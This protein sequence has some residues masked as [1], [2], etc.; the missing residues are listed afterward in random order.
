[1]FAVPYDSV[2][3]W[4]WRLEKSTCKLTKMSTAEKKEN[5]ISGAE[6][7]LSTASLN[8][9]QDFHL[10]DSEEEA[11]QEQSQKIDLSKDK[12]CDPVVKKNVEEPNSNTVEQPTVEK[13]TVAEKSDDTCKEDCHEK[14][15]EED[16]IQGTPPE[17]YVSTKK[18]GLC[19]LETIGLKRKAEFSEPVSKLLRMSSR[20][21]A[22][23]LEKKR[24]EE[25]ESC[26]SYKIEDTQQ[27]FSKN[28]SDTSIII[29][30]SQDPEEEETAHDIVQNSTEKDN[31]DQ[32][33]R[34][35]ESHSDNLQE[36]EKENFEK[37]NY[38]VIPP[39]IAD[40]VEQTSDNMSIQVEE[41]LEKTKTTLIA[42]EKT[43][44]DLINDEENKI[45][46]PDNL[47]KSDLKDHDNMVENHIVVEEKDDTDVKSKNDNVALTQNKLEDETL[48]SS[49]LCKSRMSVEVIYDRAAIIRE[50]KSKQKELVQIDEDGEKI[51]LDSSQDDYTSTTNN[52]NT[53]DNTNT[54]TIY[55]SCYESKNSSDYSY[56][57]VGSGT[58]SST[59]KKSDGNL[60]NGSNESKKCDTDGTA[61]VGSDI[62]S[63]SSPVV[64]DRG[65]SNVPSFVHSMNKQSKVNVSVSK[66]SDN[67]DLLSV[68][69]NEPDISIMHDDTKNKSDLVHSNS[70]IKSIQV[71]KEI[72]VYL[73][74]KCLLQID[75]GTK[76]FLGKELMSVHCEPIIE[77]AV[78]RQRNDD[79]LACL[80]DISGNDNKDTSP[81]SVNSN[82][83]PYVLNPSRLSFVST[84]SSSSSASSAASLASKLASRDNTHFSLPRVP[85]KHVKKHYNDVP[86]MGEKQTIDESYEHLT[87][88]WKNNDLLTTSVLS[89]VNAELNAVDTYNVSNE[90]LDDQL[91]KI[92]SSTPEAYREELEGITPKSTRRNKALKRPRS[93]SSK[94]ST[95]SNGLS[96]LSTNILNS[97]EK[98]NTPNNRKK[99]KIEN[100]DTTIVMSNVNTPSK[101]P[102]PSVIVDE[103]IGKEVFAKW[104]DNNYYPGTV[105]DKVKTKYKVSFYDGKTKVLIEDFVIPIPKMLNEG[106][107]V[108]ATKNDDYGSCGII[109]DVQTINNEVYYVVETDEGEKIKVQVRNIFL[110]SDQAQVLK[111]ET[112]SDRKSLP[113]TP[114]HLGQITLDNMIDGKRRSKRIATPVFNTPK[115]KLDVHSSATKK[116]NVAEPSVSGV[117]MKPKKERSM[118]SETDGISSDASSKV[119]EED[120][121]NGVQPEIIG[122][123]NAQIAKG[124]QHRIKSKPRSKKR[125]D[126]EETIETL[127]PIPNTNSTIFKGMSFILTCASVESIDR[128]QI[129]SKDSGS[130][131]GTEN[132][133]EWIQTPFVRDRLQKQI[134][135]GGGKVYTDFNLVPKDEYKDTKLITNV[136]NSTAKSLL[137]LSVGIPAYNHKWIIRCCQQNE[138]VNP[139]EDKL[140]SGWSLEKKSYI[141]MFQRP[142]NK[143]LT[144]VIVI[145]PTLESNKEFAPFWRIICENAGA[146]VLLA[147]SSETIESFVEGTVILTN[148][149]CP[150]WV[151]TRANEL[152]IP[153]LSTTWIIQ[154][155]I[156][157][158]VCHYSNQLRYNYNFIQD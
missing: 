74:L 34:L 29:A 67:A 138:V 30:E 38:E 18:Q 99:N 95:H 112:E 124:P 143:P 47:N 146:V 103:L 80:A 41:S 72:G 51:V 85:A 150:A 100:T 129:E 142:S 125:S 56:K 145:I 141:E 132:E 16:E 62:F 86:S 144:Q 134:I 36:N 32:E 76:E 71:E 81:G 105:M 39:V 19:S 9:S 156:E 140:P 139:D 40:N 45:S 63:G 15:I 24:I 133:E 69:D 115:S 21:D 152:Q 22:M 11:S 50:S 128:Y 155:L 102:S 118:S 44:S 10:I 7:N 25:E 131:A 14:E 127:G 113:S 42:D 60:V 109:V 117:T 28:F 12:S 96:A 158:K 57:S 135:A 33:T 106:L 88:E 43:T 55:K 3:E 49:N 107:S 31:A 70:L 137:C 61:S 101:A 126:D 130:D 35:Q 52:K 1:M 97:A 2:A 114:K 147:D 149:R 17:S 13:I 73:R 59:D 83:Q 93:K 68:S 77:S 82:P 157:G 120:L 153:L 26:Q 64:L 6:N 5:N 111:E 92:R 121:S 151:V 54:E 87:K 37:E 91:Q 78:T 46:T 23:H 79:T 75:E 122:T 58:E 89:Y 94:P 8:E 98:N 108:Y 20:E 110:S 84:I 90:R 53:L 136:P 116:T 66:D 123:P 119:K 65:D 27:D 154:C 104:S 148:H 48:A 4:R